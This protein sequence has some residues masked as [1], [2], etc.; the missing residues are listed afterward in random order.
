MRQRGAVLGLALAS[1]QPRVWSEEIKPEEASSGG[2]T[3]PP[4]QITIATDAEPGERLII[5]GRIFGGDGRTPMA[6]ARL[7]LYH[8]DA[9]GVYS[10][11]GPRHPRLRGWLETGPDGRY[12]LKTIRPGHYPGRR[13]P[14]HIHA[15]LR[16]PGYAER[17]IDDFWFDGDPYLGPAERARASG[18]A[19][20]SPILHLERG[21]DGVFRGTRDL[22]L[23]P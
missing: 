20:F 9:R 1:L 18:N 13:V 2:P 23:E 17:W 5:S 8:T 10:S 16:A 21:P 22:R 11:G 3:H 12:E 4:S 15:T 7:Y 19:S 14:A 6:G